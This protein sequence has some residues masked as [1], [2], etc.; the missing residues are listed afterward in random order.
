MLFSYCHTKTEFIATSEMLP[1]YFHA[2]MEFLATSEII[3]KTQPDAK[4]QMFQKRPDAVDLCA[5]DLIEVQLGL[6]M[7][8]EFVLCLWKSQLLMSMLHYIDR[9]VVHFY[10]FSLVCIFFI[11]T[12]HLRIYNK[13]FY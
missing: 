5:P 8:L 4:F 11:N 3:C 7:C 12:C 6:S 1:S 10:I 2:E 13:N 9:V